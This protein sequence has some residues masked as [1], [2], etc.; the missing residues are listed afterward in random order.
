MQL[1][2]KTTILSAA[3]LTRLGY[4]RVSNAYQHVSR[5]DREDWILKLAAHLDRAP[6]D[7]FIVHEHREGPGVHY[8]VGKRV[9]GGWCDYYRR[10]LSKDTLTISDLATFRAIPGSGHDDCG[11]VDP[12]TKIEAL[13]RTGL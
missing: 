8:R 12:E 9:S 7:L 13:H 1:T 6:A 5:I 2:D 10:C 4:R 3:E 11:Y